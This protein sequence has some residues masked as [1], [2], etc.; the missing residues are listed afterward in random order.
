MSNMTVAV[1]TFREGYFDWVI[2]LLD[3]LKNQSLKDFEVFLVV[4]SN[5]RYFLNLQE[6]INARDLPYKIKMVFNPVDRGIAHARNIALKNVLTKYIV[7][8]DD[9][10]FP[11][12]DWLKT[13]YETFEKNKDAGAVT[14]PILPN[15]SPAVRAYSAVFPKEL[16]WIIGCTFFDS[17]KITEVRNGFASNLALDRK[18]VIMCGEFNQ[19][20]GYNRNN[21]MAGEELDFSIR[22]KK[23]G[24]STLW[25]PNSI[26]YHHVTSNRLRLQSL[27]S[28]SFVEGKSKACLKRVHDN[29]I[30]GTEVTQFKSVLIATVKPEAFKTKALLM[31]TTLAVL[32]G[33][34][35]HLKGQPKAGKKGFKNEDL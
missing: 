30:M 14:G 32:V 11:H 25:N 24:K 1:S 9:D 34:L 3:S 35:R 10:T 15:W 4:N 13:L 5:H 29:Y 7:F 23:N 21:P 8:T 22:L 16:Y 6:T 19:A 12:P 31:S 27:L 26:V 28:R 18:S 33:Y 20:F 2:Q 17:D